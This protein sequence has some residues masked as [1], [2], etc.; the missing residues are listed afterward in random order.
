VRLI[1]NFVNSSPTERGG[2]F[3]SKDGEKQGR[4]MELCGDRSAPLLVS[5]MIS[6]VKF[7]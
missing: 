4:C 5:A 1:L 2:W 6:A 7:S 3:S